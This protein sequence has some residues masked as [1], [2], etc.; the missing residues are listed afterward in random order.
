MADGW[1]VAGR[2]LAL[3]ALLV[4]LAALPAGAQIVSTTD[5]PVTTAPPSTEPPVTEAPTVPPTAPPSTRARVSTTRGVTSTTIATT[6]THTLLPPP[7]VVPQDPSASPTGSAQSD[8]ISSVFVV[9]SILGFVVAIALLTSQWFLTRPG[10]R[11]WT[12]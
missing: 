2:A 10:R 5:P 6:T 3:G 7:S 8:H 1:R 4:V 9:A 11:G 12:F